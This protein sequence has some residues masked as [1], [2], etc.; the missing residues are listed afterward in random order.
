ML[1]S[2]APPLKSA[3]SMLIRH[4]FY[5]KLRD[6]AKCLSVCLGSADFLAAT[7]P[8]RLAS[9]KETLRFFMQLR[10]AVRRRY[11]ETVDFGE[12]EKRIQKLIDTHVGAGEVQTLTPLVNIFD[13]QAFAQAVEQVDGEGGSVASKADFIASQTRRTITE[14]MEEDPAF[15]KK[16]STMLEE[17]IALFKAQRISELEYLKTAEAVRAHVVG[18]TGDGAPESVRTSETA[19]AYYGIVEQGFTGHVADG[20]T[21]KKL[22]ADVAVKSDAAVRGLLIVNW[23]SNNDRKNMMRTE[24]EDLLLDLATAAGF[25]LPIADAESMAELILGVATRKLFK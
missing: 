6:Y 19:R 14:R 1:R 4:E 17:A 25:K 7:P 3:A 8:Q 2:A 15:Y 22:A 9:Y 24:L 12:Y 10:Y 20:P 21:R 13:E 16:F 18:H 5:E 11:A 23:T